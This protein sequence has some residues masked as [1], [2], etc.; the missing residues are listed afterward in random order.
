MVSCS[1]WK[2]SQNSISI[3][4]AFFLKEIQIYSIETGKWRQVDFPEKIQPR[5]GHQSAKI[6]NRFLIFYGGRAKHTSLSDFLI[7]D[8]VDFSWKMTEQ[9]KQNKDLLRYHHGFV[10]FE[11]CLYLFG[12]MGMNHF[13]DSREENNTNLGDFYRIAEPESYLS[14][15]MK[16]V[17]SNLRY[18][19]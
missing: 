3:V 15:D 19:L 8:C 13:P 2:R 16:I 18:E 17:H 1:Y 10:Y 4:D 5:K 11:K 9:I 6:L 12:G 7:L 14:S